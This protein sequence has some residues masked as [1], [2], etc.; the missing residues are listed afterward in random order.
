MPLLQKL[1]SAAKWVAGGVSF[2]LS[3]LIVLS[4]VMSGGSAD[5]SAQPQGLRLE[6]M[7][8]YDMQIN[9]AV[10][11]ALQGVYTLKKVYWL[12]DGAP[13]AP[14]PDPAKFGTATDPA[15]LGWLLK[16]AEPLLEGQETLFSTDVELV[17]GTKITYY[18]DETIFAISWKQVCDGGVY[19]FSEVKIAHPSQFRRFLAGGQYGSGRYMK[20][21]DMAASVN[22]VLASSGDFYAYRQHGVIVYDGVVRRT[23]PSMVETCYI[24][25]RGDLLF[26]Y[27]GQLRTKKEAQEFVDE[28]NIRFSMAFGP[29]L[30]ENGQPKRVRSYF[31]GQ[32]EDPYPRAAL[33]Q[34][35]K[36]HYVVVV[37]GAEKGYYSHANLFQFARRIQALDV[38]QAYT[39]DGGQTAAI[40]MND[41]PINA[42]YMGSQRNIS[43]IFYF[44]TAIPNG[45]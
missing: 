12:S 2:L 21:T 5:N 27:T 4:M 42:A 6:I 39:L 40:V 35:D 37:A 23:N 44:A 34:K 3:A 25:D 18:L 13:V 43:D 36:L 16:A 32:I 26:S 7:D 29:V 19:T 11:D 24:T 15:E 8:R 20:T 9:N 31:L 41:R 1:P 45:E 17:P 38:Q 30:V 10:S 28:N 33:C 22:A 14:E